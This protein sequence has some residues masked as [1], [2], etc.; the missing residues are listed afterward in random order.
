MSGRDCRSQRGHRYPRTCHTESADQ[1]SLGITETEVT[2][3][4]CMG[5]SLVL[6]ICYGGVAGCSVGLLI[7]GG[8][9][10]DSFAC[11]WGYFPPTG[12]P[13]SDIGV[14]DYS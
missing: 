9:V 14:C 3:R 11:S 6:R 10:S 5:L 8:G 13:Q 12:L 4:L 2:P 7:G 1:S